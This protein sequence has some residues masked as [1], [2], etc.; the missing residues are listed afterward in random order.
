M[1]LPPSGWYPDP[2][3]VPGLLRWW[4]GSTWTQHTHADAATAADGGG[5]AAA[6]QPGASQH[7]AVQVTSVQPTTVQPTTVQPGGQ[8]TAAPPA[9]STLAT[10]VPQP[11]LLPTA[12]QPA[13]EAAAA[14]AGG[15][16]PTTV[17][18][19]AVQPAGQPGGVQPTTVQPLAMQAGA[20]QAGGAQPAA[21]RG[22]DG[23]GTQVLFL[24][25]DTWNGQAAPG[26]P[27]GPG[28]A[29]GGDWYGYQRAQRRRR[30]W[31]AG[32]LAGGTVV[33]LGVI[34]LVVNTLGP[35][36]AS[37]GAT[38]APTPTA[39]VA[40]ATSAAPSPSPSATA[41]G[42][43]ATLTD[44]QTGLSYTQLAAPWG[45]TCPG[46]MNSQGFSWTAGE[47]ALAG[48]VNGGQTTWYGVAC[49]TPLPQQYGYNGVADLA[50]VTTTLA[51][52]FNGSY[53][54]ALSHN[55]QQELS[56]PVQV[57]GHA[58]WE[59]KFL[60]TYTNVSGQ[61][62]SWSDEMGAVV[63]ADIGT[64]AAPAVFYV[65][66]P[67]NLGESNVDT[68]VSSLQ[69]SVTPQEAASAS[70][71]ATTTPPAPGNGDGNNP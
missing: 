67:G 64:G 38:Q 57:S 33:A 9:A 21:A 16:Q 44:G 68:L 63:V 46:G 3:G 26:G 69:L 54:Q 65:S 40:A 11:V 37:S 6:A 10:T 43:S 2:F 20:M 42:T 34:A 32:G 8:L 4:D 14:Q 24:G 13:V 61:G 47:S 62:L 49:S 71:S 60:I 31:V 56:Q 12:V 39:P 55:Y 53:Y 27:N 25:D 7:T 17:Q 36:P 48:Q 18:P 51:N 19:M 15:V 35:S 28:G 1:E 5:S 22:P 29:P 59:V 30:I 52:Q 70:A 41:T 58:G 50:N 23:N 45:P 66:V